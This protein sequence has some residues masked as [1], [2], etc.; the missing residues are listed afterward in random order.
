MKAGGTTGLEFANN[1]NYAVNLPSDSVT[2][3]QLKMIEKQ[4]NAATFTAACNTV[5]AGAQ[6][7]GQV[8]CG[9]IQ[10][11]ILDIDYKATVARYD[12]LERQ[13]ITEKDMKLNQVKYQED[14]L[15]MEVSGQKVVN[16]ELEKTQEA[17]N[18]LTEAKAERRQQKLTSETCK[19]QGKAK[20]DSLFGRHNYGSPVMAA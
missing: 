18:R 13:A 19:N 20:L 7:I 6:L 12:S 9:V 14:K 5:G 8:W 4:Q 17:Q 11:A 10:N 16:K 2:T 3:A 15:K 1:P